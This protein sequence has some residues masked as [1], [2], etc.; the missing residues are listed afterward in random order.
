MDKK[1][2]ERAYEQDLFVRQDD[3]VDVYDLLVCAFPKYVVVFSIGPYERSCPSAESPIRNHT[4]FYPRT[5][6]PIF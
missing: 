2:V 6:L 4:D 5:V 3:G 1:K